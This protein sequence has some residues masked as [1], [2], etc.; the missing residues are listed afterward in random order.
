MRHEH[1]NGKIRTLKKMTDVFQLIGVVDDADVRTPFLWWSEKDF[2]GLPRLSPEEALEY[3]GLDCMVVEV[4]N[5]ELVK[6]GKK[7][8]ERGIPIH[9][10]KP[11]GETLEEYRELL[12]LCEKKQ[13]PLQMGYMYRGNPA[14]CFIRELLKDKVLGNLFSA[15][16]DMHHGYAGDSYQ[17]YIGKFRGGL[18]HN[19]GCHLIDFTVAALGRPADVHSLMSSALQ[20]PPHIR[21]NCIAILEYPGCFVKLHICSRSF[22]S[23]EN[24]AWRF[25]GSNGS[26][27]VS[28][29]E[30]YDGK[31]V[32][33]RLK[34]QRDA[35]KY[36]AG[37]HLFRFP[38]QDDRYRVQLDQLAKIVRKEM[39]NPYTYA[40]DLLVHEVTLAASGYIPW[41]G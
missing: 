14:L 6:V 33:V 12:E 16:L 22:G 32:E 2:I 29:P 24:R 26:I 4:P 39:E 38:P 23:V 28:P 8:V 3:P 10:D 18:M 21:N 35:G 36:P 15:E 40:H 17:E 25:A 30:R 31:G 11:A 27:E 41:K 7:C 37:D 1:A 13:V 19:L 20:D 9:L 5:L 34:L